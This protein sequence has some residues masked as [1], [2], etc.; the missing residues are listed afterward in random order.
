MR[1]TEKYFTLLHLCIS[2]KMLIIPSL[3]GLIT[4]LPQ[5]EK[6]DKDKG[7]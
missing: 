7:H 2:T 6:L 1:I 5:V 4:L 3:F